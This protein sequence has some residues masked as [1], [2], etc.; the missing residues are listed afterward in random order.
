M[1]I[2]LFV[3]FEFAGVFIQRPKM[4]EKVVN[5]HSLI[6][7]FLSWIE[8]TQFFNLD[9]LSIQK[10]LSYDS[11]VSEVSVAISSLCWSIYCCKSCGDVSLK[12]SNSFMGL[13]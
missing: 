5:A 9:F 1:L 6:F 7:L 12:P 10:V 8:V 13:V 3:C 2:P 4:K 11:G